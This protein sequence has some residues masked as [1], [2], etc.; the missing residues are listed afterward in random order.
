MCEWGE[1]VSVNVKIP[2]DLSHTKTERWKET[3]IDRCIASIV[4]SLQEGGVDMRASCCGHG[5]T[6]GRILLQDGR[7]ILILRDC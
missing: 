5:N 6:A 4:R 7:T 2:A 1:T 3:E